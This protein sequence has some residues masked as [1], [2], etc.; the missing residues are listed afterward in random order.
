MAER[1]SEKRLTPDPV[2]LNPIESNLEGIDP[3]IAQAVDAIDV[4]L[5]E[6][7]EANVEIQDDGSAIVGPELQAPINSAF[8]ANLV[9]LIDVTELSQIFM[10]L[11]AAVERDKGSRKEWEQTYIDGLKYLGMQFDEERSQPFAGAT[12][13]IHPLLGEAVTQFQAQAYKELLPSGGPVKTQVVGDYTSQREE[14]AQR[15]K[16]FMNYQLLHVMQEYDPNLDQLLFYLPLSGSAFKKIYYNETMGRAMAQ[17]I[18]SENLVVP[19]ETTDLLGCSR[20]THIIKMTRNEVL[21]L[22]ATGFYADVKIDDGDTFNRS[23]V[24]EQID[25]LQG[26]EP[27]EGDEEIVTIYE[28]HTNLDIAGFEDLN[29]EGKASGIKLPY[30]V[31]LDITSNEVLS[32]R[33]NW[34]E[35][36]PLK[37]KIEYFV[38]Y[39]FLPGLGFYGFGLTH[40][41]GG[42]SKAATSILRQLIDA[43]TLSNLPAGFKTRGIRI[44]DE[45]EPIQPGEFRDVDAPGSSLRDSLMPLPFK[46]PSQTLLQLM[47]I[48]VDSGKRF[49]S[50][51]DLNVGDGNQ[52][53]PVGTTVALL[54][55]GTKVMSAIHKRLHYAQ[56]IEFKLLAELFKQYLPPVYPYATNNGAQEVKQTDFDD[57][58]DILP[59]SNPDIFST[60]QRIVMAQ[61]MLKLVQ[62]NPSIHGPEGTFEAYRRV[63]A[64]LGVDNIDQLLQPPPDPTPRPVEACAENAALISGQPAQAFFQQNHD[65]HVAAHA[66]LLADGIAQTNMALQAMIQSHIFQ[67]LQLKADKMAMEKMPPETRQ[68]YDQLSQQ[69]SQVPPSEASQLNQQAADMLAQFSAPICAQLVQEFMQTYKPQNDEDPLVTI[70]KQELALKGQDLAQRAQEFQSKEERQWAEMEKDIDVD[71]DR[72]NLQEKIALI[73]DETAQDR[74][75]QADRFHEDD[76]RKQ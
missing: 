16:E 65:A 3:N 60:S 74:L 47:G 56:N 73:R 71:E 34:K 33:R 61:E 17:F 58:I 69:A 5:S 20:I 50:I 63:Y 35:Q 28:L 29:Q 10:D 40:M 42:L 7:D 15:V 52:A 75:D 53:A 9:D 62:S 48:L 24:T 45:A 2:A 12:G 39:K 57:R 23:E 67:H 21:K 14:Q 1:R 41:I 32:I 22:Q 54:E 13:V 59:V 66:Q 55:R 72:L 51:A 6:P 44:R 25:R 31:T 49:A 4:A 8:T 68:Q 30:I 43:G 38:H 18:A 37:N 70:R 19:Y 64:S 11:Y 27:N 76:M 46:E 36:D 26:V